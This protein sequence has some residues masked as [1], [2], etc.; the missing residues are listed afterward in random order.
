MKFLRHL[1]GS[2]EAIGW[3][4][5]PDPVAANL[6]AL[7]TQFEDSQWWTAQE[8]QQRQL[9]QFGLLARHASLQSPFFRSRFEQAGLDPVQSWTSESFSSIPLLTRAELMQQADSI[10]CRAVPKRHGA[11]HKLQTSGSTGQVV[12]VAKTE[13]NQLLWLALAMREHLWHERDFSA[14]LAVIKAL[15]PTLDDP[16]KAAQLGW[17]HPA[18]LLIETGPSYAQPLA[19]DVAQQSAWLARIDPKYLLTYPS[20]LGALLDRYENGDAVP[21]SLRQVRT[22]GETLHPGLRE[23]CSKLG[24]IEIVDMYSSQEVGLIALQC[25]V[26]GLYHIQSESLIVEVLDD[27]GKPCQPGEIG[28]IV[29]TDLHN[30]ATPIIRYEIRDYAEVGPACTCGRGLSTLSR[31]MGRRRNM[32]VLPDGSRHW[33]LIGAHHY[34]EIAD[35]RQYQAVQ[36][37]L[38]D[39]EIRLVVD[40]PLSQEQESKLTELV[41]AALGH[42]FPLRYTCSRQELP[43][44][45]G[46]KFEEFISLLR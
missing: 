38:E 19:M 44:T 11:V 33:P 12:T 31:I 4:A 3:P 13:V 40:A 35:I 46:G 43:R 28:R 10:Y 9:D 6:L 32:V 8:L 29:I 2:V 23:R 21:P 15:T 20:N 27:D 1:K 18:T 42:P 25:P 36:H 17:G 7:L 34:R 26:S 45:S 14:T 24:G 16:V 39:I 30:F 5:I 22:V 41:H 37:S